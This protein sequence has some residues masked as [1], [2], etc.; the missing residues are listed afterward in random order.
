MVLSLRNFDYLPDQ[1]VEKDSK[2]YNDKFV[3]FCFSLKKSPLNCL[4]GFA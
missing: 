3:S 2:G 1:Q 4:K